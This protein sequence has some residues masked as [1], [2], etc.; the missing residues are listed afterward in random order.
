MATLESKKET[1]RV[2]GPYR[3]PAITSPVTHEKIVE[4]VYQLALQRPGLSVRERNQL[5][6]IKLAYG[7]GPHGVRGITY[8]H[9]WARACGCGKAHGVAH[10]KT[11]QCTERELVPF[12]AVCAT[13]QTSLLQA[14]GTTLHE[15]GHVLAGLEAGHGPEWHAA[16]AKLGLVNVLAAGTAYDWDRHIEAGY[17]RQALQSLPQITDDGEPASFEEVMAALV[18]R[19]GPSAALPP[20]MR[21][22]RLRPCTAGFGRKGGKSRTTMATIALGKTPKS[23]LVLWECKCDPPFKVRA[24]QRNSAG[25][26]FKA[27]CG[28]CG[29]PFEMVEDSLPLTRQSG[30]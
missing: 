7:A 5:A 24:T 21:P 13:G 29:Q 19:L 25:R 3:V 27:V 23:R 11:P 30:E 10:A 14:I 22:T 28:H 1:A 2:I 16:C 15:L 8:F 18:K 6:E 4:A 17:W 9:R 26:E 12:V 20:H